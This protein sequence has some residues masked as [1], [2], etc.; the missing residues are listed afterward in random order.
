MHLE[1]EFLI[2]FILGNMKMNKEKNTKTG[3][4]KLENI[5]KLLLDHYRHAALAL[6]FR[7]KNVYLCFDHA[8]KHHEAKQNVRFP[9]KNL[10]KK[11]SK[12][13]NIISNLLDKETVP[14]YQ[15]SK[16]PFKQ[17]QNVRSY[18]GFHPR[19][20]CHNTSKQPGDWRIRDVGGIIPSVARSA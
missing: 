16:V 6:L 2:I 7:K 19:K 9:S 20:T 1:S 18:V 17:A 15:L 12:K 11:H 13:N 5:D 10:N 8:K 4:P 3:R 14:I